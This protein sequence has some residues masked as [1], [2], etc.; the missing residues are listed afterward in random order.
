[1]PHRQLVI[2][3]RN[4]SSWSL[5]PWLVLEALGQ[6]FEVVRI[7]LDQPDTA[8][9]I[10]A[11]SAAGRV[12]VLI[13]DGITVWDSLA[14]IEH[15]AEAH[16]HLWPADPAA[17]AMVRSIAAEMHSG[18]A[19]LRQELPMNLRATGRRVEPTAEA[20]ADIERITSI[21]DDARHR[22]GGSGPWLFGAWSAA[23]AMYAPVAA[24]FHTYGI[25]LAPDLEAYQRALL[26]APAMRAWTALAAAEHETI[27]HEEVGR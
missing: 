23:D 3:N 6:P 16:P 2:G 20:M 24:R 22:F 11:Y 12:P 8:E 27:M 13:E 7:P 10:R 15:L 25:A 14:I 17:R 18:F 26:E 4:Y 19:A 21:W 5:R 9:R 1:M